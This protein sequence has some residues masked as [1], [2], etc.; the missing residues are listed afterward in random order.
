[1]ASLPEETT[2]GPEYDRRPLLWAAALFVLVALL[3]WGMHLLALL[4]LD[5]ATAAGIAHHL[6]PLLLLAAC[7]WFFTRFPSYQV[8]FAKPRG[9]TGWVLGACVI[10]AGAALLTPPGTLRQ[11][12]PFLDPAVRL[13]WVLLWVSLVGPLIEELFMRGIVQTVLARRA[14]M[15]VATVAAAVAFALLHFSPG[16]ILVL[17]AAGLLYG[18][19]RAVGGSLW[20]ALSAHIGWNVAVTLYA[21]YPPFVQ[22]RLPLFALGILIILGTLV[23]VALRRD[24]E[25]L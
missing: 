16:H 13:V 18:A 7:V 23:I 2:Q 9:T 22:L 20:P 5:P 10:G 11:F 15:P 17:L 21:V 24:P 25:P 12:A 19:F 1:M 3:Y 4:G 6:P 14:G 8:V